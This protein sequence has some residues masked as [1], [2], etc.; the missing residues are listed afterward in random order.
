METAFGHSQEMIV[1]VTELN[2]GYYSIKFIDENGCT[3]F[4]QYNRD[5]LYKERQ[6]NIINDIDD[7]RDM[8]W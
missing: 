7:L 4:Y 3:K 2:S 6:K 1:F 5:L 8:L